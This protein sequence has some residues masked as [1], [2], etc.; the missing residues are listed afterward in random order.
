MSAVVVSTV[1]SAV[2]VIVLVAFMVYYHVGVTSTI[3]FL[4]VVIL[5]QVAFTTGI[6]M[7]LAM[8][9]LFYRDVKYLFEVVVTGWMFATSVLYPLS[10]VG[11]WTGTLARLNPMS[12]IIDAYRMVLFRG[13]LPA[14]G[15]FLAV[16][17]VSLIVLLAGSLVFHRAEF[18]FARSSVEIRIDGRL[19]GPRN[20]AQ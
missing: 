3:A 6:A 9:N 13:E 10:N 19:P 20:A 8:G 17:A 2:G 16:T 14:A 11:G 18:K 7:L 15:P 5:V 12:A 1:D 4:P